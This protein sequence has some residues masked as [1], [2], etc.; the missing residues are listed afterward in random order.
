MHEIYDIGTVALHIAVAVHVNGPVFQD[1]FGELEWRHI[2]ATLWAVDRDKPEYANR[3]CRSR[4]NASARWP[5]TPKM[6]TQAMCVQAEGTHGL[7]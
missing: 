2:G 6:W 7:E 1:R 4:H 3:R 5:Q